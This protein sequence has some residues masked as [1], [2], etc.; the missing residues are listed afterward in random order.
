[1]KKIIYIVLFSLFVACDKE[2]TGD[3]FQ[4]SG[5]IIQEVI[6]V[7]AFT[8]ILVNKNVT[9][10]LKEGATQKV[11]VETGKNL[12]NDVEVRVVE[13]KLVLT[14]NNDCNY[15]RDY[16]ITKVF[17]TAPSITEIRSS[18]QY[19][20]MSD[21]VLT[22]PS[23]TILSEDFGEPDSFTVG[24]FRLQIDNN[25]FRLV[26]NNYSNCFISGE[27]D[28]LNIN[29]ASGNSRFEGADLI[30]QN[31]SVNHRGTNDVIVNPQQSLTGS[32]VSYGN[33]ISKNKPQLVDVKELFK[34]ELIFE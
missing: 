2:N 15:V 16:G 34:G 24:D 14:D 25:S 23:L 10:I 20:I 18:T 12:L 6:I 19:E 29:F 4:A 7:D 32:L 21:G 5:S 22:Y 28:N 17:V 13:G 11:V 3:C 26:F 31:V 9:L 1:M 30:A 33:L 8:R 27:T